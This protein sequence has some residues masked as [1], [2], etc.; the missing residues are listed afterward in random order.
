[1]WAYEWLGSNVSL[2]LS[3]PRGGLI[4][5]CKR[6]TYK[7]LLFRKNHK[8]ESNKIVY[9]P[10]ISDTQPDNAT[11]NTLD[12]T[13]IISHE[14]IASGDEYFKCGQCIALV[15]YDVM[16]CWWTRNKSCPHCRVTIPKLIKYVN[17]DSGMDILP[18][19]IPPVI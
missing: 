2:E 3:P 7:D 9:R 15:K 16:V 4:I 6:Y 19:A 5:Q 18:V 13:C 8:Y 10:L 11:N 17:T 12:N 1:V 14:P